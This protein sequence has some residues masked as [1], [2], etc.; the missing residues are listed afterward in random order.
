MKRN[1]LVSL[2]FATVL[3]AIPALSQDPQSMYCDL[4]V[5]SC[6]LLGSSPVKGV[7]LGTM[8]PHT[9]DPGC[10]GLWYEAH[11]DINLKPP[12]P[13]TDP[14]RTAYITAEY[15][16]TPYGWTVDIGDSPA[17]NGY[18]GNDGTAEKAAEVQVV[19]Q[20]LGVYDDNT[21]VYG[22][23]DNMLN[24]QLALTN[25]SL[26]FTIT[27]QTLTFG[28]PR[29]VLATPVTKLLYT[30]PDAADPNGPYFIYAAFNHVIE[31][32]VDRKGCG[33]RSVTISTGP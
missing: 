23:V 5:G 29:T 12:N 30:L 21:Q 2:V 27:D 20:T 11:F 26:K 25:G 16:G 32:A 28:E 6:T 7:T 13:A 24:Q 1:L 19:D 9:N 3:F 10:P 14:A 18:G 15:Q 33:V 17:D 8:I 31:T 4:R 22:Q